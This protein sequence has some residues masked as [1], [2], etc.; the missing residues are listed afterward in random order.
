MFSRIVRIRLLIDI[1]KCNQ[2][3]LK[4]FENDCSLLVFYNY[5]YN[6]VFSYAL[7]RTFNHALNYAL[8]YAFNYM[9]SY[10][11]FDMIFMSFFF[12]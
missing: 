7:N 10:H 1:F 12:I 8:N 5:M 11:S 6:F 9:H 3:T 2:S 4:Q